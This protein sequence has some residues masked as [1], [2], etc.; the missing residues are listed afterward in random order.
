MRSAQQ[1]Y[2]TRYYGVLEANYVI[3]MVHLTSAAMGTGF[4]KMT[5]P[6]NMLAVLGPL[7]GQQ[8][9]ESAGGMG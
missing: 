3:C 9:S 6:P 2:G 4:W 8:A 5:L 7:L 1:V